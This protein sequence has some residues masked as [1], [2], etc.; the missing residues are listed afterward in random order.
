MLKRRVLSLFV[1]LILTTFTLL[2]VGQDDGLFQDVRIKVLISRELDSAG[3]TKGFDFT[4]VEVE[5]VNYS[6]ILF[7][8]EVNL[9]KAQRVRFSVQ[10]GALRIN[11]EIVQAN[12]VVMTGVFKLNSAKRASGT[13]VYHDTLIIKAVDGKI[14]VI[15]EVDLETYTELVVPSE[16]P[17]WFE[18]EAIKAQAVVARSRAL[19]DYLKGEKER[20]YGAHCDDSVNYQVFNNQAINDVVKAAVFET[21]GLILVD[22]VGNP[23]SDIYYFSTSGG[24]TS[25][26]EDVWRSGNRFPGDPNPFFRA[27]PQ[28]SNFAITADKDETFWSL[29]YRSFWG[30]EKDLFNFYD[31]ESPWFR[32]KLT[33]AREE[34]ENI[35]SRGLRE[36]ERADRTLG[37]DMIKVVEGSDI[38]PDDANFHVGKLRDIQVVRSGESGIV[39]TLRIVAENGTY[40][41]NQEYNIRFVVRPRKD[42]AYPSG[43]GKDIILELWNG[44]TQTNYSILPSGYFTIDLKKNSIGDIEKITFWG[45]GNGHGVGMSQYG[46]NYLAKTGNDFRKILA[47]YFNAKIFNVYQGE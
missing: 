38:N 15:N 20:L 33:L 17:S 7:P 30:I 8:R 10:N 19:A 31:K 22:E 42:Y 21:R 40:E 44:S 13:P 39:M 24:F 12:E 1:L 36:R 28:F 47:T 9:Q 4:E 43:G 45:G 5:A 25:N 2:A 3:N 35:V 18:K 26:N 14:F 37:I 11:D 41:I 32:W 23:L 6:K 46:A 27:K 16:V 29:F 34:F